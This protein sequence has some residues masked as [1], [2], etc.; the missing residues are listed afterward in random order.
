MS[1]DFELMQN[2]NNNNNDETTILNNINMNEII[3]SVYPIENINVSSP[4]SNSTFYS[5]PPKKKKFPNYPIKN[6]FLPEL[7]LDQ[8][9]LDKYICGICENV[10]DD[11]VYQCCGCKQIFCRKCLFFYYD[12]NNRECPECKQISKE[13]I[14]FEAIDITIKRKKMKCINY[15]ANCTWIGDCKDYKE[16][17]TKICP[18]DIINCPYKG[19]IIKLKREE[20]KEHMEK[21][22]YIEIFCEKCKL[23]IYKNQEN[24]HKETCLKEK[25]NCPQGCEEI[26]ERGDINLHKQNCI[27][28]II[29]CPYNF[30]GCSDKFIRKE[31]DI[32][33]HQDMEKHFNLVKSKF[34]NLEEKI[35]ELKEDNQKL[36]NENIELKKNRLIENKEKK[37]IK[38]IKEIK[39][40]KEIKEIKEIKEKINL[41]EINILESSINK[42][43]LE[44]QDAPQIENIISLLESENTEQYEKSIL[45][46]K[47]KEIKATIKLE[48]DKSSISDNPKNF[49]SNKRKASY[50]AESI[51]RINK[52]KLDKDFNSEDVIDQNNDIYELLEATKHLFIINN[53]IIEAKSLKGKKQYYIFF[54]KKYDIPKLGTK[55]YII[56]YKLLKGTSWIG[57]GICDKRIVAKNNYEFTP[58][59]RSDGKT[60]NIGTYA[61]STNRMAWNCNNMSQCRKFDFII[62]KEKIIIECIVSPADCEIEFKYD[63]QLITKFND[64]RCFKSDFFS[65]CLILL[66]NSAVETSFNY[67]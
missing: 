65:P 19:C 8:E 25:I 35:K 33:L 39:E 49:L 50:S 23:K 62:A 21:C 5:E 36:K 40:K 3:E 45:N 54:K 11:P 66:H 26:I 12:N 41:S 9:Y 55:K 31:K 63:N 34:A 51:S 28:S 13:P 56:K 37:Q 42:N 18:K 22:E 27:Y 48:T 43:I 46:K 29:N 20:M 16:H 14:S 1:K 59:R 64:V 7:F 61:I 15:T 67:P 4:P 57:L 53:N 32:R 52:N 2:N 38:E 47:D 24:I 44:T 58:P 6:I 17:I 10:C 60:T 30:V